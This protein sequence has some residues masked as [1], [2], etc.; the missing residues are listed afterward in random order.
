MEVLF[1]TWRSCEYFIYFGF[2]CLTSTAHIK[3]NFNL[4]Y[5]KSS[6]I[7]IRTAFDRRN[8]VIELKCNVCVLGFLPS[9]LVVTAQGVF[10]EADCII[11]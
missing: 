5:L 3:S 10:A 11:A 6:E 9:R 2:L 8:Q 1:V 7:D 4:M